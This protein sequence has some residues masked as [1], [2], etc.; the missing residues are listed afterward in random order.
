[1]LTRGMLLKENV[2]LMV[3]LSEIVLIL[4]LIAQHLAKGY[5]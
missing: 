3:K 1:V 2:L 5:V 4:L